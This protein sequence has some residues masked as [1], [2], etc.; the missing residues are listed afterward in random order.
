MIVTGKPQ[1]VTCTLVI[2]PALIQAQTE[3]E[4]RSAAAERPLGLEVS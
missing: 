3:P 4:N 1:N 2:A